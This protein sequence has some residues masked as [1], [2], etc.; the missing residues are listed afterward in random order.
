VNT[1]TIASISYRPI[2]RPTNAPP[3]F[4][5]PAGVN[6]QFYSITAIDGVA[7]DVAFVTPEGRQPQDT[8]MV[9]HLHGSGGNLYGATSARLALQLVKHGYANMTINTRQHDEGLNADNFF[10]IRNDIYA[11]ARVVRS[12]GYGQII[13]H[14]QSL[15]TLHVLYYAATDWSPDI[16]GLV[17]TGP[18]ANLPWK[19]QVLIVDNDPLYR[20]LFQQ[21]LDAVHSG[22]P[23]AVLPDRMPYLGG[24][25]TPVTAQH[26]L[27][28]RWQYE[29]AAVS[30]DWIRRV[31]VPVL[32]VRDSQDET[33]LPFE[34]AW[35]CAAA[36]S[37]GALC[38][39]IENA[40]VLDSSSGNGHGFANAV[41]QLADIVCGW[42]EKRSL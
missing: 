25:S 11:A 29:A 33:V 35:L 7:N 3:D 8:T 14:G 31:T 40:V 18:F 6:L 17:L 34:P 32:L 30:V 28:Y 41:P 4:V 5:A 15:G 20:R 12:I 21:A 2:A 26:F 1:T 9:I 36:T 39:D 22:H 27:T 10:D 23:D 42:L 16:K 19:S 24:T 13:L 38:P 37:Y